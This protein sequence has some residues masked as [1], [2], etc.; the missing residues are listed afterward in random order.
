MPSEHV[1]FLSDFDML[2]EVGVIG[3]F[4]HFKL[5]EIVRYA[6]GSPKPTNVFSIAVAFENGKEKPTEKLNDERIRLTGIKGTSFGVF[7]S[8][9][10]AD[11]L[12]Q[13]LQGYV[14]RFFIDTDLSKL[15][16]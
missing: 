7:R 3:L 1:N 5:S 12:R 6:D 10:S 9:L 15:C 4:D 2:V 11:A 14:N 13:A 16:G 8:V